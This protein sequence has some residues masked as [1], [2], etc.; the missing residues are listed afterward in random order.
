M[1]YCSTVCL[2]LNIGLIPFASAVIDI[3]EIMIVPEII[4]FAMKMAAENPEKIKQLA[5][6]GINVGWNRQRNGSAD[7][8]DIA[9][10]ER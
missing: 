2:L 7:I 4:V 3:S 6:V 10:V 9:N 8:C 1:G 5:V